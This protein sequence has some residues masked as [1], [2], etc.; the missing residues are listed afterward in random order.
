MSK[1]NGRKYDPQKKLRD[2]MVGIHL[3][4]SDRTPEE[5]SDHLVDGQLLHRNPLKQK[6]AF[7]AWSSP[8]GRKLVDELRAYWKITITGIFEYENQIQEETRE[9]YAFEVLNDVNDIAL[10]TVREIARFGKNQVTTRFEVE[11]LGWNAPRNRDD[12]T[13]RLIHELQA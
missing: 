10:D 13:L 3:T 7:A 2:D 11:L 8:F 1:A 9:L 4:W 5:K 12:A 6:K